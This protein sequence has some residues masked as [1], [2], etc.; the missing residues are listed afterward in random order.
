MAND[1]PEKV[2]ADGLLST[3]PDLDLMNASRILHC[4]TVWASVV[5][6]KEQVSIVDLDNI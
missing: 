1:L 3:A 2:A 5:V 4:P 6:D